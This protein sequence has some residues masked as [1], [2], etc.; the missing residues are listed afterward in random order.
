[1]KV[2]LYA[3]VSTEQ[4]VDNYSIDFQ[5]ERTKAF[6]AS[7]GWDNITEYID[8][9]FSGSN[10]QRPAL[11]KLI[12]DINK[13][14]IDVV[15]VY[16]LD[17]LSRSQRDTLFLI[18]ELF[19][20]NNV[21]F[22]SLNET[23]DTSTPF[24][25]AMIGILSVF[26]QLERE[27]ITE[28]MKFGRYKRVKDN[29]Y[30][31]GGLVEP[32]GYRIKEHGILEIN[33]EEAEIVKIIYNEYIKLK[34]VKLVQKR[35]KEL[36]YPVPRYQRVSLTLN[37]RLYIGEVSFGN[38][39]FPGV[40]QP[41]I[42]KETFETV[43]KIRSK[44]HGKNYGKIKNRHFIGKTECGLCGETYQIYSTGKRKLQNGDVVEHSYLTC[45]ARRFP[46]EYH[47][48]CHNKRWR[49]DDVEEILYDRIDKL[50]IDAITNQTNISE[51]AAKKN[52]KSLINKIDNKI[53]KLIDLYSDGLIE[54]DKL[55]QK[56]DKL[57]SEKEELLVEEELLDSTVNKQAIQLI[58]NKK[59]RM[60]DMSYDEQKTTID[61]LVH[62][63]IFYENK[64]E[65]IWNFNP[66]M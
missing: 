51:V 6:C 14:M 34:S 27:T 40:H 28:R 60:K 33:E 53:E 36:G 57:N 39:Y 44:Q 43:Q 54:K 55:M 45:K 64:I 65:V 10:T 17:R 38:E 58:K 16:R 20:P 47:E 18:E 3:R 52:F 62:K 29:G 11:Q 35:L 5:K 63:I 61:I 2:A 9:G 8:G 48:K 22:I 1:M 13:G 31:G 42:D 66:N 49:K 23:I 25:R 12:K 19:L 46:H 4:Q 26:A 7:K 21:E 37:R 30:Y 56:I 59:I 32:L 41:I 50:T 24:G 15:I